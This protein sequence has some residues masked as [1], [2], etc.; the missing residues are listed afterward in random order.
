MMEGDKE[1]ENLEISK[2]SRG[3]ESKLFNPSQ[4]CLSNVLSPR[5]ANSRI[6]PKSPIRIASPEKPKYEQP[7]FPNKLKSNLKSDSSSTASKNVT[8]VES[9]R[10]TFTTDKNITELKMGA[11]RGKRTAPPPSGPRF[12]RGRASII[13]QSSDSSSN[14][15]RRGLPTKKVLVKEKKAPIKKG[16]LGAIKG[17]GSKKKNTAPETSVTSTGATSGGRVLRNRK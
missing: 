9:S 17:I 3:P 4:P 11:G 12:G 14:T 10:N 8:N 7:T 2:R 15:V 6:I 13:S 16:V 1:N 5:S